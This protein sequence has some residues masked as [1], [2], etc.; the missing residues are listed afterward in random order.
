MSQSILSRRSPT[1]IAIEQFDGG[2]PL[3]VEA[4]SYRVCIPTARCVQFWATI[5]ACFLGIAI[6][7]FLMLFAGPTGAYFNVGLVLLTTSIGVLIPGPSYQTILPKK[8][9]TAT[10][11]R[12]ARRSVDVSPLP[13]N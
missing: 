11:L 7:L 2:P 5:I 9:P 1:V 13:T 12:N 4:N 8:E 3:L 6:G 10:A